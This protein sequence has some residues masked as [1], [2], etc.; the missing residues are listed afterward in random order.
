MASFSHHDLIAAALLGRDYDSG[1]TGTKAFQD[2]LTNKN[3]LKDRCGA[4]WRWV[5]GSQWK[6][7]AG[8]TPT[9]NEGSHFSGV[10]KIIFLSKYTLPIRVYITSREAGVLKWSYELLP[11]VWRGNYLVLKRFPSGISLPF[12]AVQSVVGT[13]LAAIA[14]PQTW[15]FCSHY[16]PAMQKAELWQSRLWTFLLA[17][18][19]RC[20][21]KL[22][23]EATSLLLCLVLLL[24]ACSSVSSIF[25]PFS[26]VPLSIWVGL[27]VL[28]YYHFLLTT[29][30]R[31]SFLFYYP[32]LCSFRA[33]P[34]CTAL[35]EESWHTSTGV[36][37]TIGSSPC[38]LPSLHGAWLAWLQNLPC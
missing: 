12:S 24:L 38:S 7:K 21:E 28:L 37:N 3:K 30:N 35:P 10:Q 16:L 6:G 33:L 31:C 13:A 8:S 17:W 23:S 18:S 29:S 2:L 25:K 11:S 32:A 1:K 26:F 5:Q 27:F 19:Q 9:G 34:E 15:F 14:S 36:I 22:T 20:L 4:L